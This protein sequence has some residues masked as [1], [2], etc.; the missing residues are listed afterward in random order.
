MTRIDKPEKLPSVDRLLKDPIGAELVCEFGEPLVTRS[1]KTVIAKARQVL[2]GTTIEYD[3]LKKALSE[4]VTHTITPS[5]RPVINSRDRAAH[6]SWTCRL[7]SL[8]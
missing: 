3:S 4:E 5:L 2:A 6:Q 8:P 7:A 1:V